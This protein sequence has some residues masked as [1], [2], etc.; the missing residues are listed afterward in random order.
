MVEAGLAAGAFAGAE[1][2]VSMGH[3]A[4]AASVMVVD[5]PQ[6]RMEGE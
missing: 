5:M 2:E 3:P 6:V 1:V 4:V